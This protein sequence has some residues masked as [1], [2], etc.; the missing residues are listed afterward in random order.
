[1]RSGDDDGTGWS[2][3]GATRVPGVRGVRQFIAGEVVLI[4]ALVAYLGIGALAGLLAGLLGVGGGLVIVPMLVFVFTRQGFPVESLMHLALGTS[5]ASIVFTSVSSFRAHQRRGA[6]DWSI[7]RGITPGILAGTFFGTWIASRLSTPLLKGCFTAFLYAVAVQMLLDAK[8]RPTRGIPG[9]AGTTAVGGA[10]GVVSS[11]VGIGGGSLSVPFMTWCNV[12]V[13][14]A[15]GT[16]AAIGFP[17]ALAG[18]AGYILNGLRV[19]GLPPN[20]VGFVFLPALAAIVA[21]SV[22]TAPL[23]AW[24]AHRL[25]VSRL[26]RAFAALLLVMGTRLLLDLLRR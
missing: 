10:I 6:V 25:P 11:L 18:S 3:W 9:A 26:K 19:G 4:V 23:G 20:A 5:M 15:I 22:T 21:A 1:L 16:S 12:P 8:P 17:I 7:V 2:G 13:H 14:R 24:I